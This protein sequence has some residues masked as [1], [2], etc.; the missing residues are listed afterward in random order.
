LRFTLL[1]MGAVDG[2]GRMPHLDS[3]QQSVPA[4]S[5]PAAGVP[6]GP[7]AG[8]PKAPGSTIPRSLFLLADAVIP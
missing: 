1:P 8:A 3:G 4:G 7:N 2:E 5:F 6:R